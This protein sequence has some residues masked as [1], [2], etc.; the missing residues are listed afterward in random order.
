MREFDLAGAL[1]VVF[2]LDQ[3]PLTQHS[4]PVAKAVSRLPVV[5]RDVAVVVAETVSAEA[6]LGALRGASPPH[7]DHIALFDV[8]R[9]PGIGS[10]KKSL[11]ILVL[12]QDT[13]RTLT[14]AEIDATV[15]DLLRV[16]RDR[17]D[18]S[19]RK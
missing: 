6:V 1:P 18:A 5:R 4:L 15:T 13:A 16:L 17:F 12:M 3:D 8:Y 7:V 10:G 14:D 2:E 9:G 19:P 11:A